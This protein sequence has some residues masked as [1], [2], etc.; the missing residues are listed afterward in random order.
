MIFRKITRDCSKSCCSFSHWF[1]L[2]I[3]Q[4][5]SN[6]VAFNLFFQSSERIIWNFCLLA[7]EVIAFFLLYFC[8]VC[9]NNRY[10]N[11]F[12]L[13]TNDIWPILA[14]THL[15]GKKKLGTKKLPFIYHFYEWI[16]HISLKGNTSLTVIRV[17]SGWKVAHEWTYQNF[18]CQLKKL[19]NEMGQYMNL[20]NF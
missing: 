13:F 3:A 17:D 8:N 9:R 1:L 19:T 6:F 11:T 20:S 4:Y 7:L 15:C 14:R 2:I 10:N 16:L 5:S 12:C 18:G